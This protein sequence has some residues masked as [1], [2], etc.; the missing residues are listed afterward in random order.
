M[1]PMIITGPGVAARGAINTSYLTVMDLAPTFLELGEAPYPTD[2]SVVPMLGESL[3]ALLSGEASVVHDDS[4]ITTLFHRGRAFLRQGKWK[5]VNLEPPFDESGFELFDLE[6]DPGESTD[7]AGIEAERL[8]AMIELWRIKR[9]ELGI[10]L[11][12]DL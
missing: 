2:G 5:L 12:E 9:Q 8:A 7:L 1:A 3:I 10:V 4:Y 11:P 6:A